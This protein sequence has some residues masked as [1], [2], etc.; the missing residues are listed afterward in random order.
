MLCRIAVLCPKKSPP[1]ACTCR[2]EFTELLNAVWYRCPVSE[3]I[4][5][6]GMHLAGGEFTEPSIKS[7]ILS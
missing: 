5:P 7:C 1:V 3:K 2:G 6:G 4:T